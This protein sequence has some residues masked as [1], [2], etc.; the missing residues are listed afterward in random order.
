MNGSAAPNALLTGIMLLTRRQLDE[1]AAALNKFCS[2]CP[3]NKVYIE[4][5]IDPTALNSA[6]GKALHYLLEQCDPI[7]RTVD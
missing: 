6:L 3:L 4:F 7:W 1:P 2:I 5:R